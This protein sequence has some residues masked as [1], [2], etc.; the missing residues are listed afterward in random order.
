[1]VDLQGR[2]LLHEN[3]GGWLAVDHL[4]ILMIVWMLVQMRALVWALKVG[5]KEPEAVM[6]LNLF[7][8]EQEA[9]I[10]LLVPSLRCW[11][12]LLISPAGRHEWLMLE[13]AWVGEPRYVPSST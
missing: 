3:L 2:I 8:R 12:R 1:M 10:R 11:R 7:L 5:K 6:A 13:R 4:K 9:K